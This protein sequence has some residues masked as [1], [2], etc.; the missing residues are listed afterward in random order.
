MKIMTLSEQKHDI[1]INWIKKGFIPT[2][3]FSYQYATSC[4]IQ[5]LFEVAKDGFYVD[6][7]TIKTAMLECGFRVRSPKAASWLFN[8][9]RKSPALNEPSSKNH[10]FVP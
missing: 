7:D 5:C 10:V 8:V 4:K 1:L 6:E 3:S 9:S 2:K